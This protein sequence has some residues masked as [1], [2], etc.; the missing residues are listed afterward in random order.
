VTS[1]PISRSGG[2]RRG[3]V[4]ATGGLSDDVV[5]ERTPPP[6]LDARTRATEGRAM[7]AVRKSVEEAI[8]ALSAKV[9]SAVE[10]DQPEAAREY[11]GALQDATWAL[12]HVRESE[13]ETED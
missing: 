2:I 10:G 13:R 11:A 9:I 6:D 7:S 8:I 4:A 1:T 3:P 5:L 12:E